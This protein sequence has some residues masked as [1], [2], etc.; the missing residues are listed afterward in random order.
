[1]LVDI[2][3]V[4]NVS[5]NVKRSA[6]AALRSVYDCDVTIHDAQSVPN[7]AYDADRNQYTAETFIQLAE[8]V[9]RGDKNIAI[10]P[11]DLFYRRRNYVFGLA[12][13][14][15]SGSVVSTYRLQTSSDGGFS[16]QSAADIFEDRVRKEIVHEIG[17]TYGLEHCDNN[18]CVMNFSPT[19]REVDIKEENLCG[20]C[21]RLIS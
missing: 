10:T 5:A 2:V 21:Q 6:S 7:G 17:H 1:M 13:L 11:H 15:G 18:R 19:V 16:N 20:S 12:Y 3:P 4:G 8:R 9:G 14:D